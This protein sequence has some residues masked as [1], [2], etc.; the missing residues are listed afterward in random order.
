MQQQAVGSLSGPTGIGSTSSSQLGS[1]IQTGNPTNVGPAWDALVA[2]N[3]RMT[4]EGAANIKES[5]GATGLSNSSNAM[6]GL[7]DYYTQSNSQFMNI[8]SQYTMQAQESAAQRQ[9]QATMFGQ[10]EFTNA[11]FT[12]YQSKVLSTA[13]SPAQQGAGIMSSMAQIALMATLM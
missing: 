13:G 4:S 8:L 10:N 2:A 11:A 6:T 12:D 9:L 7:T 3:K 1:E 5:F